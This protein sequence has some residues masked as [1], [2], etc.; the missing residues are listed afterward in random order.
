MILIKLINLIIF[1]S[2]INLLEINNI[3]FI[4]DLGSKFGVGESEGKS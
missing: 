4:H 1:Y 2:F 3:E